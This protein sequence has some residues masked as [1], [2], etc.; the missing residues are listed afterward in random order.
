[1]E[2][3]AKTERN[4]RPP[5]NSNKKK[6]SK[7]NDKENIG[8]EKHL[9]REAELNLKTFMTNFEFSSRFE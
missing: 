1:M 8:M 7:I 9:K 6:V 3:R 2:D 4:Y 5:S